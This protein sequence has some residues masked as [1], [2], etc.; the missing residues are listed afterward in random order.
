[1]E[2]MKQPEMTEGPQAWKNFDRT[3]GQLLSVS[4]EELMRREKAY[5]REAAKNPNKRGPKPK[6]G[7]SRG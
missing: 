4:H 3:M 2:S 6:A 5:K 7:R 1:M